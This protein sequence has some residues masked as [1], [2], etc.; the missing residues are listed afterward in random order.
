MTI[1]QPYKATL[2]E[3]DAPKVI[4]SANGALHAP[5]AKSDPSLTT[6]PAFS[7]HSVPTDTQARPTSR[8][9][10]MVN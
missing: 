4:G 8:S 6:W 2:T 5:S 1:V 3:R 10:S 7:P 9:Y